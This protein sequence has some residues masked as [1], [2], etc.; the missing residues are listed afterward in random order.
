MPCPLNSFP[1]DQESADIAAL[2]S[3]PAI[4]FSETILNTPSN[5]AAMFSETHLNATATESNIFLVPEY[6]NVLPNTPAAES[7]VFS[8]PEYQ[9]ALH[10]A[11]GEAAPTI[12]YDMGTNSSEAHD[13]I[14]ANE[15]EEPLVRC[16]SRLETNSSNTC[17]KTLLIV[18]IWNSFPSKIVHSHSYKQ[19]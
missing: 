16:V 4:V 5:P 19:N 2:P 8:K 11:S 3:N 10:D 9:N 18:R 7:I 15:S 17:H 14:E 13:R 1:G 12:E 6:R